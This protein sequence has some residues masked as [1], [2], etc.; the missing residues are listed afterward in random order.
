ML[1]VRN[2]TDISTTLRTI[3]V[4]PRDRSLVGLGALQGQ[5]LHHGSVL[6]RL[7]GDGET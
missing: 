4:G 6:P 7:D 5:T 2:V 1:N 3:D